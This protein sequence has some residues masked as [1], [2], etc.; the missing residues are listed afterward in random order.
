MTRRPALPAHLGFLVGGALAC[1]VGAPAF[2]QKSDAAIQSDLEFAKGL[3]EDWQFVGLAEE[4]I[5]GVEA[6]GV[7]PRRAEELALLKCDIFRS[8]ALNERDR[9]R[10]NQ[11]FD[12]ALGAYQDFVERYRLSE[13]RPDAE[14]GLIRTA[15]LYARSLEVSL[16]EA[17][18]EEAERLQ[19]LRQKTL[20][21]AVAKTG[22]L[23]SALRAIP[24][25]SEAQTRE[26]AELMLTRARMLYDIGRTQEDGSFS[27]EQAYATAES[28]VYIV[29]EG[30]PTALRC[31]DLIGRIL[32]AQQ[33]WD[34]AVGFFE[35]VVE[36]AIPSRLSDWQTL[37]REQSLDQSAKEQ[38]WL[39][40]ELS[41]ADLAQAHANAGDLSTATRY[42]LHFYN[43]QRREGF[44]FSPGVG[45]PTLIQIARLLLDSGGYIGGNIATGEARWY[46]TEEA[47]RADHAR[48]NVLSSAELA[49]RI[50]TQVKD[51]NQG[52]I[53]QLRAQKL[54]S[55]ISALPGITVE[56]DMLLQAAQGE[57]HSGEFA[58]AV[59]ALQRLL[60]IVATRDDATRLRFGGEICWWM[61]R[62]FQR[63]DRLLEAAM[64]FREGVVT[65]QG[66]PAFDAQ[67]AQLF[68]RTMEQVRAAD[69]EA[70]AFTA[71]FREAENLSTRFATGNKD[72]IL[73]AQAERERTA[74]NFD[75]A[76]EKYR[77]IEAGA[78]VYER[79]LVGIAECTY[80]KG[81]IDEAARLF[82][83]YVERYVTDPRRSVADSPV[84]QRNR[85]EAMAKAE[86]YRALIALERARDT[87]T[88]LDAW[89]R[90]VE[91]A[92]GYHTKY[93]LQ[94]VLAAWCLEM[95]FEAQLNLRELEA[96]RTLYETLA[97]E[98]PDSPRTARSSI[99]FYRFLDELRTAAQASENGA[100]ARELELEMAR[101]L[102]TGN[103]L[104]S[105]PTYANLR[106]E[107][108]HWI[109]LGEHATAEPILR[110][111]IQ[112][113]GD[114]Q[115]ESER[116]GVRRYVR[117]DLGLTLLALGRTGE[118]RQILEPL[119]T[120]ESQA[121][122]KDT[123]IAFCR[124]MVG[125]I[126][127]EDGRVR[128]VRGAAETADDLQAAINLYAKLDRVPDPWTC[129][130]YAY[131][132]QIAYAYHV[133]ATADGGPKDAARLENLR[134]Q[135][136]QI[137]VEITVSF[138]HV[139]KAC[140][141]AE[142]RATQAIHGQG[143]LRAKFRWLQER[144]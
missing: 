16:E 136:R 56:P 53:L 118:A 142:A 86:F 58:N 93:P 125:W 132:F 50:A 2:A 10:R 114:S 36:T 107:S 38:R 60:G 46:E 105:S 69:R 62:S 40:L 72:D 4:V 68:Y 127:V 104:A 76:I 23:V 79:G 39:F 42:A 137:T 66:D 43:T 51:E 117:P 116:E 14:L 139:D 65:W 82:E 97:R 5:R 52:N 101:L 103:R 96:T 30:T 29:G 6:G 102:Q 45:Y 64:C 133:W 134:R 35:A 106:S 108:T 120:D 111:I 8:A 90:V 130:W 18:G 140:A 26:L 12:R 128:A 22:D 3:A 85:A 31:F 32:A 20:T 15:W 126:E 19:A 80:R 123:V 25:R 73:F 75:A 99:R 34:E 67:N 88:D 144:A 27:F 84:R 110:R 87:P 49:L 24:E 48:R 70:P 138:E 77:E 109:N 131:K 33:Q 1:A 143:S 121:P 9:N 83:E 55:E 63:M 59:E 94:T 57:Y 119:A 113:Y 89:R 71:L 124:A 74:N 100:L 129:E 61:G 115:N 95:A 17:I 28:L 91:L 122:S 78:D 135:L 37:V 44:S 41:A 54:I 13:R 7:S 92:E 141:Q 112:L 21:D 47:A 11:L 98:F 81:E